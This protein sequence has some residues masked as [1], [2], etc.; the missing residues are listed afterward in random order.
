MTHNTEHHQVASSPSD[1]HRVK[2][3]KNNL[4]SIPDCRAM[5]K[6]HPND[7]IPLSH[8]PP[9]PICTGPRSW[10][11][12][13][14][15]RHLPATKRLPRFLRASPSTALDE[16]A[17]PPIAERRRDYIKEFLPVNESDVVHLRPALGLRAQLLKCHII[18]RALGSL[19][20]P[21][22]RALYFLRATGFP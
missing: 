5:M 20:D 14:V 2:R 21:P 22:P 9:L 1:S 13:P 7:L 16:F 12:H 11:W 3:R 4:S 19:L 8:L 6:R 18:R 15:F 10:N 17:V